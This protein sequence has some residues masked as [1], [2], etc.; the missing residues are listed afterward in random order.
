MK[1]LLSLVL[2]AGLM[3]LAGTQTR[4]EGIKVEELKSKGATVLSVDEMKSLLTGTR[5]RYQN[6]QFLT[7]MSL[8][9]DG[10]LAGTST[11][12]GGAGASGLV[13]FGGRWEFSD[14]GQWCGETKNF[15]SGQG[16][17]GGAKWCRSILKLDDKYYYTGGA[18]VKEGAVAYEI[19]V[20]R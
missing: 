15:T 2:V 20:T 6:D 18:G 19:S 3:A 13:N 17:G 8:N 16:R 5:V 1:V 7:Q 9:G 12:V 4:A 10:T 14:K 11:R